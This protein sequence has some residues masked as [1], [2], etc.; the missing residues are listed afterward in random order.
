[1]LVYSQHR[2]EALENK[3]CIRLVILNSDDR[4]WSSFQMTTTILCIHWTYTIQLFGLCNIFSVYWSMN[5]FENV[6]IFIKIVTKLI[7]QKCK[8]YDIKFTHLFMFFIYL[9]YGTSLPQAC[10]FCLECGIVVN[11]KI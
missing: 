6:L 10:Q 3:V 1:M 4:L 5:P 8:L 7:I 9:F 2:K 11:K